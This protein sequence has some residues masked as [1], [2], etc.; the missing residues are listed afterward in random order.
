VL[1]EVHSVVEVYFPL[2]PKDWWKIGGRLVED[3]WKI[4]GRLGG[5]EKKI[6]SVILRPKKKL[7]FKIHNRSK[8]SYNGEKIEKLFHVQG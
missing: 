2:S 1:Q 4:G 3:W 5:N 6:Y 7:K 8:S